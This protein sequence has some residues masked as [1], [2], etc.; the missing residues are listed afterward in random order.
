M[1]ACPSRMPSLQPKKSSGN[2]SQACSPLIIL[3][4]YPN[5]GRDLALHLTLF[6]DDRSSGNTEG[7]LAVCN[8]GARMRRTGVAS[9]GRV[10]PLRRF[11]R[12]PSE[13]TRLLETLCGQPE[14]VPDA[15]RPVRDFQ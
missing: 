6:Y 15:A 14:K 5:I 13:S 3:A 7:V 1:I 2:F 8:F 11:S 9:W 10:R 12:C 4:M